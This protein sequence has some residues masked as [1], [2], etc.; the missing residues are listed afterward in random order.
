MRI[1]YFPLL[2]PAQ[3][4]SRFHVHRTELEGSAGE[5]KYIHS[6]PS[7]EATFILAGRAEFQIGSETRT[8]GPG[9]IVFFPPGVAHGMIRLLEGPMRYVT[10][11]SIEAGDGPCCCETDAGCE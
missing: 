10:V 4:A 9:E 8:A 5:G 7:E 3:G 6:H 1:E 2:G 11:R